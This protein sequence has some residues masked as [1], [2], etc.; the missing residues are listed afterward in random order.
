MGWGVA[1]AWPVRLLCCLEGEGQAWWEPSDGLIELFPQVLYANHSPND[2]LYKQ[3]LS[4]SCMPQR[5]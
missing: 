5:M 4:T 1:T 2:S 3:L